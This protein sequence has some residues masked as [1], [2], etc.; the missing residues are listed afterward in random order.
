MT[1]AAVPSTER[2][3]AYGLGDVDVLRERLDASYAEAKEALD[4]TGGDVVA[5][6]AYIE[7]R[8]R[9]CSRGW[10]GVAEEVVDLVRRVLAGEK[11]SSARVS[12]CGQPVFV[13]SLAL[14]GIAGAA[15]VVL[16]TLISQ[17]GVQVA[18]GGSA[19]DKG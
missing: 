4:A 13:S 11:V 6:L 12:L 7:E 1:E 5:A 17:C 16:S 14:T 9:E 18:V 8:R 19:D 15:L 10:V 3:T 2:G